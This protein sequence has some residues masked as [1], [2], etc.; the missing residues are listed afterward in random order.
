MSYDIVFYKLAKH[1]L[2]VSLLLGLSGSLM[3]QTAPSTVPATAPTTQP[4]V[5]ATLPPGFVKVTVGTRQVFTEP[6]NEAWVKEVLT[7]TGPATRPTTMPSDLPDKVNSARPQ[8]TQQLMTELGI[9]DKTIIDKTFD[10]KILP[11]LA[12]YEHFTPPLFMLVC[13]NTKLKEIVK[14]GW[15]NPR[16]YY[17]RA[18]DDV[19]FSTSLALN[20][21]KPMDDQV[22]PVLFPDTADEAK[23]REALSQALAGVEG[24]LLR[25]MSDDAQNGLQMSIAS[26]VGEAVLVPLEL[27]PGQEWLGFGI[28]DFYSY[29][30]ATQMIGVDFDQVMKSLTTA[31][32]NNPIRGDMI[33]LIHPTPANQLRQ[34]QRLYYIDAMR[35]KSDRVFAQWMKDAQGSLLKVIDAVKSQKPADGDALVKLVKDISGVDLSAALKG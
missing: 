23:K 28:S 6:A 33:D 19:A 30:C 20:I 18:L 25:S 26:L 5:E 8:I 12:R 10:E 34:R 4:R 17:N 1:V 16:F 14:G 24:S 9:T 29:G 7:N 11:T 32:P 13:T 21:D 35:R 22:L 15:S 27:K 31:N 3:A 2:I